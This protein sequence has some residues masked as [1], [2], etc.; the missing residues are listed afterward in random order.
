MYKKRLRKW[1]FQKNSKRSTSKC[2]GSTVSNSKPF[3]QQ[4][5]D[6]PPARPGL[7]HQESLRVMFL[8]SVRIC[9]TAF[10]ESVQFDD[11]FMESLHQPS[12]RAREFS[13]ALKLVMDLLDHGHGVLAGR[14]VRKAFLLLE[15]MMNLEGP[16]LMWNL[17]EMMHSMLK[18]H[19]TRLFQLLLGHLTALTNDQMPKTHPLT[20]ILYGLREL[21]SSQATLSAPPSS[22]SS[23]GSSSSSSGS[24]PSSLTDCSH[25][26]NL[27]DSSLF[28]DSLLNL[29]ERAWVINAE[30]LFTNF[31]PR[32]IQ[33]YS[34]VH[35]DSCSIRPPA[36]IFSTAD[37][38]LRSIESRPKFNAF[39]AAYDAQGNF[40]SSP[41]E[42]TKLL[43]R[44]L[45]P[46]MD[47]SPPRDYDMLRTSSIAALQDHGASLYEH[48]TTGIENSNTDTTLRLLAGLVKAQVLDSYAA[49]SQIP[50]SSSSTTVSNRVPRMH[51]ESVACALGI[52]IDLDTTSDSKGVSWDTIERH[53]A[54]VALREYARGA[55]DP[56][57]IREMWILE[58]MLQENGR[59]GEAR[60]VRDDWVGRLG[61]Y[62]SDIPVDSV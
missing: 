47:K 42:E 28:S 36:A 30:I 18:I 43:Q 21:F 56:Q 4:L 55:N 25:P 17:L 2:Q 60:I 62:L 9:S 52:L 50:G 48:G 61:V 22:S 49:I 33:L 41:V 15:D 7:G 16:A 24:S 3:P 54:I 19:H 53:R 27:I 1:G 37:Q 5:L 32:L 12:E 23:P 46:R 29:I 59:D 13:Y 10:F 57:V 26:N 35:W 51:A 31:D 11:D 14:T 20:A 6:S 38:W 8:S 39:V 44:L 40:N 34:R 45:I 58:E